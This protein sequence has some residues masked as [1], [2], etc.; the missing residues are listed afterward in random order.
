MDHHVA[1]DT[2]DLAP[3]GPHD[4]CWPIQDYAALGDGRSVALVAPD[5]SA[6]WWCAPAIDS[7]PLFDRLLHRGGGHFQLRPVGPYRIQRRYRPDS[8]VLESLIRTDGGG[9]ARLL[10][11][12]NSS[13]AGRLPWTEFARRIEGRAGEVRFRIRLSLGTMGGTA[14]PWMQPTPNGSIFHLGSVL[15]LL[16]HTGNVCV[17]GE[18]DHSI[19]AEVTVGAGGRATM[20]ILAGDDEPLG[21]PPIERIDERIDISDHAWREWAEA[22]DYHGPHADVVRRSAL[23]LK[24]LIYSP[25]GAIAAAATSSLPER[26]GGSKN[27]DYRYAW[28]RDAAYVANAFIRI[29]AILEAKAA[30]TWL[31]GRLGEQG[32]RVLYALS[33]GQAPDARALDDIEGYRG[34][35]PV[36]IGNRAVG[37][38]QH[39]IYGDI[40]ETA[41]LFVSRGN[42]LD[43]KSSRL[44]AGLA[45]ECADR[46][47]QRDSGIWE[48]GERR[49]YTMSKIS[50]WQALARASELA[51]L[52]HLPAGCLER[53][54]RERDRIAHWI[55]EHCWSEAR[56]AY[57]FYAGAEE[58]D[59]SLALA[60]RFGF[61]GQD[62]LS[63][64]MDAIRAELGNG[65]F[66]YRYSGA[67][68]EEGAF[69]ACSF[70]MVEALC[71]LD[72]RREA[73]TLFDEI[74]ARLPPNTG[75]MA[76]MIDPATGE[77]LGN[78]P[79]GLSHL[80]LV[81]AACTLAGDT[82]RGLV[83]A[84][85]RT[86][87]DGRDG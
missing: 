41:A 55:D 30:L 11:S 39:G 7:P 75:T 87:E 14:S 67:A 60:V 53:W 68:D 57:V 3:C 15:G 59:A 22:V 2:D 83:D 71:M 48:L 79:Q 1:A 36:V 33:G 50:C 6:D 63:S 19:D 62:R 32:P 85:A 8:N 28:I 20:A 46:W 9:E 80:A 37:Q 81:H 56:G 74:L 66:L 58:L 38:H 61:D 17:I 73:V 86:A 78:T 84:L 18:T 23:A 45:D 34:S 77:H 82:A 10:E 64:T 44:L 13:M 31:I 25:S 51:E 40:F 24:L 27:W 49:H 70:W 4:G 54:Q 29:G 35:G 16:R 21:V 76:E 43:Q 26:I 65:P 42:V 52:G 72:R 69:L 47:R 5:G 12:L